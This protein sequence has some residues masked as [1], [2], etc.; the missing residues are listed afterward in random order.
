MTRPALARLLTS[1][2]GQRWD[3]LASLIA[4]QRRKNPRSRRI[5]GRRTARVLL[6]RLQEGRV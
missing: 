3:T 5:P 4:H 6:K 1:V 2:S